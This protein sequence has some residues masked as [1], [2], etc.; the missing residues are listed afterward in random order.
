[1]RANGARRGRFMAGISMGIAPFYRVCVTASMNGRVRVLQSDWNGSGRVSAAPRLFAEQSR[2]GAV[3]PPFFGPHGSFRG[4][5]QPSRLDTEA[6]APADRH[7]SADGTQGFLGG[8]TNK[9]DPLIRS[10]GVVNRNCGI[11]RRFRSTDAKILSF[12]LF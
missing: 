10:S 2:Q 6:S 3:L 1:M 5:P 7:L 9:V 8:R 12:H 11:V 4:G